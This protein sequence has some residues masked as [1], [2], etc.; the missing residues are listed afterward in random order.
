MATLVYNGK[1]TMYSL[2]LL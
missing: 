2:G 1:L